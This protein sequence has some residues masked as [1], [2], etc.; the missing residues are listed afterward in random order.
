[1][2]PG[3]GGLQVSNGYWNHLVE[4]CRAGDVIS[5]VYE[6]ADTLLDLRKGTERVEEWVNFTHCEGF[7]ELRTTLREDPFSHRAVA[8]PR[9]YAGDAVLLDMAYRLL[10]PPESTSSIG[11]LAFEATTNSPG[12]R[13]VRARKRHLA[14]FI[15]S[16]A[17]EISRPRIASLACGHLREL[18]W[19]RAAT[20]RRLGN[21]FGIDQDPRSIAEVR[22]AFGPAVTTQ[23]T[24]LKDLLAHGFTGGDLD[25]VYSAGLFDYLDDAL[26]RRTASAL[27]RLLSP[28]G[29]LLIAN[30]APSLID[31]AYME[32]VMDWWLIYRTHDQLRLLVEEAVE[33]EAAEI[34]SF[35]DALGNVAFVDIRR[36]G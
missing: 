6:T 33:H 8:K 18:S 3:P 31:I 9:G 4:R 22:R 34:R 30:L 36:R 25:G 5:S 19:S 24:N 1:M 11:R 17:D 16:V 29:R 35:T 28:G 14:S 7:S 12:S 15:D 21:F 23:C 32:A 27:L 26:A 2:S 10:P 13:S 20:E